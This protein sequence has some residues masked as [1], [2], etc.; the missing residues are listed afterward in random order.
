[1]VMVAKRCRRSFVER[2]SNS[3]LWLNLIVNMGSHTDSTTYLLEI[4]FH[5]FSCFLSFFLFYFSFWG[6]GK[7]ILLQDLF[8]LEFIVSLYRQNLFIDFGLY[9]LVFDSTWPLF[10]I[11]FM[12]KLDMSIPLW[13][14]ISIHSS[15][16]FLNNFMC[17]NLIFIFSLQISIL[18]NNYINC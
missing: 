2:D 7:W 4:C 5:L 1:M 6:W 12:L 14:Y 18:I 17:M 11:L 10:F 13:S 8:L 15:L 3:E 16:C 9:F